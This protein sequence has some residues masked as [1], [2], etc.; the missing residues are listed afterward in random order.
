VIEFA[1][2][3]PP[4]STTRRKQPRPTAWWPSK[5]W[6]T[7]EQVGE[8]Y[9]ELKIYSGKELLADE[10]FVEIDSLLARATELRVQYAH[11]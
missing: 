11:P 10:S 3:R 7:S 8:E 1:P 2:I 9:F 6:P 4:G 5:P